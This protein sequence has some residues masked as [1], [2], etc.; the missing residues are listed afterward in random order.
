MFPFRTEIVALEQV[1][2][3]HPIEFRLSPEQPHAFS[4][5]L[6]TSLGQTATRC[7]A[8]STRVVHLVNNVAALPANLSSSKELNA[9]QELY[10]HALNQDAFRLFQRN[11]VK[12][13]AS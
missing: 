1:V 9:R 7:S 2:E 3:Q 6:P 12:R 10:C 5:L 8:L 4:I 13:S 11:H